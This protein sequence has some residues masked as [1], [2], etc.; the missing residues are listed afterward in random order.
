MA[1][2]VYD[3]EQRWIWKAITDRLAQGVEAFEEGVDE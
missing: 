2:P 1:D 3:D